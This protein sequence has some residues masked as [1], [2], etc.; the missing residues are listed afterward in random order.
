[1]KT[2]LKSL[3][4]I[5]LPILALAANSTVFNSCTGCMDFVGTGSSSGSSVYP[6]TATATFPF[7]LSASTIN[8]TNLGTNAS[9]CTDGSS[10][11][12]TNGCSS[13]G[14][15]GSSSLGFFQDGVQVTSPTP[16]INVFGKDLSATAH[17]STTYLILN[18]ATTDFYSPLNKVPLVSSGIAFG[19]LSNTLTQDTN[20]LTYNDLVDKTKNALVIVSSPSYGS[21]VDPD[22]IHLKNLNSSRM[23]MGFELNGDNSS[24]EPLSLCRQG[25]GT[26]EE[27]DIG[28]KSVT[29]GSLNALQVFPNA[30]SPYAAISSLDIG[31]SLAPSGTGSLYMTNQ[32][33]IL[34]SATIS[35]NG[36][37]LTTYGATLGSATISNLASGQC[38]QTGSGG[39]LTV[40]GS[41][42]GSG[43]G[44]GSSIYAAT[45]TASFP[46][47]FTASTAS[48]NGVGDGIIS[49]TIGVS[50][51]TS[52]YTVISDS[53]VPTTVGQY[54]MFSSTSG[55][56]IG[57]PA[58]SGGGGTPATPLSSLQY[59]NGGS[60]GGI[61]GSSVG[62]SSITYNGILLVSTIA[63][64]MNGSAPQAPFQIGANQNTSDPQIVT[65]RQVDDTMGL[66]GT[67]GH[68]FVDSSHVTR[69]G[70]IGYNS[71]NAITTFDGTGPYDHYAAFQSAANYNSTG[72]IN[73]IYDY[74][75][76]AGV[77][78]AGTPTL[79]VDYY[80]GDPT[81]SGTAKIGTQVDF[82][83]PVDP[84]SAGAGNNYSFY[85]GGVQNYFKGIML[86]SESDY[87]NNDTSPSI[88]INA[89]G[90][91]GFIR[92]LQK[93]NNIWDLGS[94]SS[95]RNFF[96]RDLN[97][98]NYLTMQTGGDVGLSTNSP[99][100]LLD[101]NGSVIVRSSEGVLGAGGIVD[102][103]GLSI[104]SMT[105]AGLTACGDGTHALNWS[106]S[107]LF[108]CQTLTSGGGG[109]AST[110]AITTGT[111][112]TY[113][114]P[115]ISSPTA[116]VVALQSQ[117][118]MTSAGT[119]LYLNV[120]P[121]MATIATST[122]SLQTQ[123][124]ATGVSTG[125]LQGQI[126]NVY[127]ASTT[128]TN[129]IATLNSQFPVSLSTNT[130]SSIDLS[131]AKASGVLA[132]GR[133]P[134]LTGDITTSAG[135]LAT[136]AAS[137]QANIKTFTS[138]ITVTN[139]NGFTAPF[140]VF[141]ATMPTIVGAT[142]GGATNTAQLEIISTNQNS[143]ILGISTSATGPFLVSISSQPAILPS[144]YELTISSPL[145]AVPVFGIQADGHVVSSGA[146]TS[147]SSCGTGTPSVTGTDMA[148]TITTGT[149]SPTACTLTFANKY[150]NTP[151]CVVS[152]D[153]QTSEPAITTR[154]NTGFT[155]TLGAALTSG[156]IFY[157]CIG[158]QG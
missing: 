78:N 149:G 148:G 55:T 22:I 118:A 130:M 36:G 123:I 135:A 51:Y 158:S 128:F 11:L 126:N 84:V 86:G 87:Y 81:I 147:V 106:A 13:G 156:H 12:T 9:V 85:G 92:F 89:N 56:V 24:G 137:Q 28:V 27:F 114:N 138:S 8:V 109:G 58:P 100:A 47:G 3:A 97:G 154:S 74:L 15:G 117:F 17:G 73:Y 93:N 62:T 45:A 37:L 113:S 48:F 71:F 80:A 4:L 153:L 140:A 120:N 30:T 127:T 31:T 98:T 115:P 65:G 35:G 150:V 111:P 53:M 72:T 20:T 25:L 121:A 139:T 60:F 49:E 95:S 57:V 91:D 76:Q 151:V 104:G 119:T 101:V 6:A 34:G 33:I 16:Q 7:G 44:G 10:N 82:Y 129:N 134:A 54:A 94:Q 105:G 63:M 141:T 133:F 38:V 21:F 14:G 59:N 99:G 83:A 43:S 157:I 68:A 110:L 136:T 116:V 52:T 5:F 145:T 146:V 90:A 144:D 64:N 79:H 107:G 41:A 131:G 88:M 103:Y 46:F 69:H 155:M 102:T 66:T 132:A 125:S 18:P 61:S 152:D 108:G 67:N 122:G 142:S 70:T 29:G 124:T 39:L 2:F 96:I 1:V 40:T 42:C 19:S 77:V 75:A 26:S 32:A 50:A 143:N 23:C 112:S